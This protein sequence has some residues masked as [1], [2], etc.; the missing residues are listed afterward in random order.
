MLT[1]ITCKQKVED[2][3]GE[4]EGIR[5][6]PNTKDSIKSLT[7]QIKDIAL[8]V[9]GAYRCKSSMPNNNYKKGHGPYPY[10]YPEFDAISEGVL[11]NYQTGSSNSTP[12]WDFTST[13]HLQTSTRTDSRLSDVM[14]EHEEESKEWTAQVEPG[15]QITFGCLPQGGN[16]LKRIRF[17]RDVF[18]K[19][20]AQRWWGENYDRIME[21]YNVQRFNKH[22]LHTPSQ[23]EDGRDSNYSSRPGSARE[24]QQYNA[25]LGAHAPSFPKGSGASRTTTSSRD[26]ASVSVS[27]ASDMES[28]WIE[29]DEPGV[30]IT[31]RQLA[32]GTRELR[33]V[34]FSR[35]KFGEVN[36][37]Q[38]W[39]RNWERIQAQYL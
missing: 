3:G 35:E 31:I 24:F 27:N 8:K 34:R 25:G 18:N 1:C 17:S 28:E 12:A 23:S 26:E 39:E 30:C 22:A 29:Q 9:T 37:K 11:Y 32:D 10:P 38:W 7:A 36:A 20:Q 19:W 16:D 5:G 21:L 14:L 15:I 6:S 2:D 33:R 4:E 13:S